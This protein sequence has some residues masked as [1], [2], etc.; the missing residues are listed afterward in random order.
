MTEA[1]TKQQTNRVTFTAG[2]VEAFT[3]PPGK[4]QAFMWD[5]DVPGLGLRVTATGA[6]AY[7]VERK[8]DRQT[9]RVTIGSPKDWPLEAILFRYVALVPADAPGGAACRDVGC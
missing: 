2:R 5:T 6:K 3:C 1:A 9:V 8:L 4:A 7:I